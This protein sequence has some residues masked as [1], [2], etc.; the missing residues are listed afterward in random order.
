MH[1]APVFSLF[2]STTG[3]ISQFNPHRAV[4]PSARVM[5]GNLHLIPPYSDLG[6]DQLMAGYEVGDGEKTIAEV[7]GF[8]FMSH[9]GRPLYVIVVY[10]TC[11]IV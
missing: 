4:D 7:T 10:D 2:L 1:E 3:K 6:F 5:E 8:P 9:L 11:V